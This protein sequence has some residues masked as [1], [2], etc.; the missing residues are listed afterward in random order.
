MEQ[1]N[2]LLLIFR[3]GINPKIYVAQKITNYFDKSDLNIVALVEGTPASI[4]ACQFPRGFFVASE[5]DT[6]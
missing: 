6:S 3:K 4:N 1:N 2:N 5:Y